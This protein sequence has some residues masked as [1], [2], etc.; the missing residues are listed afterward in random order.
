MAMDG[1]RKLAVIT[2]WK[3]TSSGQK[4]TD[5]SRQVACGYWKVTSGGQTMASDS[6]Q[7]RRMAVGGS[8]TW[9]QEGYF[10]FLAWRQHF[11]RMGMLD[12]YRGRWECFFRFFLFWEY[13][14]RRKIFSNLVPNMGILDSHITFP[15][16]FSY[17]S[18]PN[19]PYRKSEIK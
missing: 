12:S 14:I 17:V 7:W 4:V 5:G 11:L 8:G 2:G 15:G 19:A 16:I 10:R 18:I 3:V 13:N 1:G 9:W 6:S